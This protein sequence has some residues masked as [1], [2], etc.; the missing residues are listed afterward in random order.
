MMALEELKSLPLKEQEKLFKRLSDLRYLGK[1]TNY[2]ATYGA[3][4]ETIARGAGGSKGLGEQ[5]HDAYWSKNW[6]VKAIAD[7]CKIKKSRDHKWLW[8]PVANLWIYLKTEKD[9]FSTLNQSTATYCFDMWIKNI[10]EKRKQATAQFHDE[11]IFELPK[12]KR[13][14]M[15]KILKKSIS[16]VNDELNLNRELDCDI[17]FG[18]NYSEVH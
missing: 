17:E 6:S 7:A 11:V 18:K 8:N 13:T 16:E 12:G 5:L 1:Q 3:G 10:L 14:V 15:T 4:A 9:K 2:A